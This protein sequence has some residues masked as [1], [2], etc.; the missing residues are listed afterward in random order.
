MTSGGGTA[1]VAAVAPRRKSLGRPGAPGAGAIH[2]VQRNLLV[3]R[4]SWLVLVSGFFEPVFYLFAM[5]VGLSGLVGDVP[6]PDGEPIS[7][8]LF[9]APAL[10]AA[11]AMNGAVFESTTNIFFK[12]RFANVYDAVLATPMR[13]VDIAIGEVGYSLLRGGMYAVAFLAVAGVAGLLRSVVG[14]LL[15]VPATLL[16]GYAFAGLG[17]AAST[18]MRSWQDFDMV[19]LVTLPLFLFSAT[20]YPID[21]YPG[22]IQAVARFS[23]L[24][25]GVEVVRACTL[26]VFDASVLG[27]VAVLVLL[28]SAGMALA[29]RRLSLLLLR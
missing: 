24:Y 2:M 11:S 4:R 16:I 27:H 10:L 21:V 1:Q 23:P 18:F 12:L 13:P 28:G 15:A 8:A 19:Q 5:G 20:F 26:G 22:A 17:M 3:H 7:Y 29:H 6:G 9:V 14:A 25:H